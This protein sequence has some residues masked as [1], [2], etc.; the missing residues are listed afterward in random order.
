MSVGF[1]WGVLR[2]VQGEYA[3]FIVDQK[4]EATLVKQHFFIN[5]VHK[6]ERAPVGP[7]V[8]CHSVINVIL[9]ESEYFII[10]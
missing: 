8:V 5:N 3:L 1:A 6:T 4:K 7:N 10:R 2:G 9:E